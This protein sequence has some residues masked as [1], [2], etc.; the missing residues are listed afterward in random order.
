MPPDSIYV[1]ILRDPATQFESV[2]KYLRNDVASFKKVQS[3][4]PF[5]EYITNPEKSVQYF[6]YSSQIL[7]YVISDPQVSTC[8]WG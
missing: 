4:K 6:D 5:V 7:P 2:F 3:S 1:T 8:G